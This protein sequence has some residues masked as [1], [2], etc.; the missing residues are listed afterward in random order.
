MEYSIVIPVYESSASLAALNTKLLE[1]FRALEKPFEILY[2]DDFSKDNSWE[3]LLQLK[4]NTPGSVKLIRLAKNYGQHNATLCGIKHASG[5]YVFTIDDDLQYSPEDLPLLLSE[6]K[7]SKA[8]LVYGEGARH[9]NAAKKIGGQLWQLGA[10]TLNQGIGRGSSMRLLNQALKKKLVSHVQPVVFLD[11]ILFWYTQKIGFVAVQT[12]PRAH[13]KS[14][15][16]RFKIISLVLQ[17]SFTYST[18]PLRLLVFLGGS[19][20]ALAFVL[21][22]YFAVRKLFFDVNVAGFTAL[23]VAI[24]FS[25]SLI[26]I[27]LAVVGQYLSNIF[28]I[29]NQKPTYSISES[30]L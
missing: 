27:S 18:V 24:M 9:T 7:K 5:D 15:Y 1:T 21:A 19:L 16:S 11:E 25:T 28:G 2:V 14:G 17:L 6:M 22:L 20:S 13:G 3:V 8:D 30:R 23:I 29:L 4:E 26:L 12:S 10:K